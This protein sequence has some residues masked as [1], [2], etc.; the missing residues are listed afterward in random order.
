MSA[1]PASV[2]VAIPVW[3]ARAARSSRIATP[4]AR[5]LAQP[6]A[7]IEQWIKPKL[8]EQPAMTGFGRQMA[9]AAMIR[10]AD[11]KTCKRNDGRGRDESVE[12]NR[13]LV[14][15][16]CEDR[17]C[18]RGQFAPA[19]RC[20]HGKRIAEDCTVPIQRRLDRRTLA[21]EPRVIDA[22]A[23]T[24]PDRRVAAE[25]RCTQHRRRRRVCD[26]H[27]AHREQIAIRRHGSV[28]CIDRGQKLIRVHCR[29]DGEVVRGSVEFDRHDAQFGA[30][31]NAQ[32]D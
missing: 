30:S 23:A 9:R 14:V 15:P 29:G 7:E 25:Q 4:R 19:E 6:H 27:L 26:T 3:H 5:R 11:V 21:R 18:D 31:Q 2:K 12:Q 28:S 20:R 22:G 16:R 24:C 8:P 32:S 17:A 13:N 10:D 1:T